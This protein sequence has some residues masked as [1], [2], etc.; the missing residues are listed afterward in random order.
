MTQKT[1]MK[2]RRATMVEYVILVAL[3]AIGT[4]AVANIFGDQIRAI[5]GA[6]SQQLAGDS[7]ANPE[8]QTSGVDS[9]INKDLGNF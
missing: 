4:I 9:E 2:K 3:V 8:D 7:S 6:S 1:Q 5:I